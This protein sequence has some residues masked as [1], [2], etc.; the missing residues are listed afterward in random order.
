MKIVIDN[1][2]P[3]INGV[4][5]PFVDVI[6]KAGAE[7][8]RSDL[9]DADALITRT[10]TICNAAILDATN[11]KFI[12]SAT[13]GFDHIDTDF[14]RRNN[15]VWT[16]AAGC[17]SLSVAQYVLAALLQ[18]S[19]K[20]NIK[21]DKTT[22]GIIGVGNVGKKVADICRLLGMN[23][24]L[25]DAPRKKNEKNTVFADINEIAENAD[26]I[27]LH[28]PL[29]IAGEYKT[30]HL[31]DK[32][33]FDTIKA[34]ILINTSRGEIVETNALKTAIINKKIDFTVVD[35]WE[36]EP[37]IDKTLLSIVDIATPHIAGYSLE[38]KAA[39]T[40]MAVRAVSKFFNLGLDNFAVENLPETDGEIITDCKNK[41][42]TEILQNI[43]KSIYDIT[44][45]DNSLKQKSEDFEK[46]RAEYRL[47][48]EFAAYKIFAKNVSKEQKKMLNLLNFNLVNDEN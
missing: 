11:V 34:K 2:I 6:Y 27:T 20:C 18:I 21:L 22:I 42:L 15:I 16:N 39:G 23:V 10:R 8:L 44:I 5:E 7:I 1:K 24:L 13:I 4:F 25:C 32:K 41:S 31:F 29:N 46:Q 40:A 14:C 38:G 35:V 37:K 47:R 45:D 36:N 26:I 33:M 9:L 19:Q 28:V 3:F 30:H 48:R 43:V 17:N 12:A